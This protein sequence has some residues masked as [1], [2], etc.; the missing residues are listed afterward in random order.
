[1]NEIK[2]LCLDLDG[3]LLDSQKNISSEV[4]QM[5][6]EL[7]ENGIIIILASGRHF[8]EMIRYIKE[9]GLNRANIAISCDGLY[10]HWCDGSHI[11]TGRYLTKDDLCILR[12]YYLY[13]DILVFTSTTDY[14]W[15]CS[16]FRTLLYRLKLLKARKSVFNVFRKLNRVPQNIKIE[17]IRID[18]T[19]FISNYIASKYTIHVVETDGTRIE[20]LSCDVN[21][22]LA[23]NR[24]LELGIIDSLDHLLYIGN[25]DND[26]ECFQNLKYTIAMSDTP[27]ELK[28]IAY[29]TTSSSDSN[30]VFFGI[31]DFFKKH[32][33][34]MPG[35]VRVKP[36]SGIQNG[37]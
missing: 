11:F 24:L 20:I 19:T 28:T 4:R 16:L 33:S 23:L 29:M 2:Y 30:G 10:A 32:P 34:C 37:S 8:N 35:S 9:L 27:P 3:T 12:K 6:M 1:M 14:R 18:G 5:I 15:I 13:E 17:K 7:I 26:R 25:D 21:K 31:K 36:K 22:F